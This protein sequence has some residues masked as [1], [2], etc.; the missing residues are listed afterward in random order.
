[1][2]TLLLGKKFVLMTDH[3]S[4]KYFFSQA[5]LNVRQ[6]RWLAFLNEFEFEIKHIKGKENKI[7]DA[8]SRHAHVTV[9]HI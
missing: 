2:E 7:V 4:L 1:M 5:N 8:L 6:A 3:I 9:A